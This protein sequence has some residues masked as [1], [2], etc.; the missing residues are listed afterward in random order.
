MPTGAGTPGGTLPTGLGTV[1]GG[2]E[3]VLPSA[4]KA[5]ALSCLPCSLIQANPEVAVD[6][7]LQ[8]A[9][10]ISGAQK[11]QVAHVLSTVGEDDP[12]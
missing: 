7:I 8:V 10:H 11:A 4:S 12:S 3:A 2:D 5:A 1:G 6:C 9:Q